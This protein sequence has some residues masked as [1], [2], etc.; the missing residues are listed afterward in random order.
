MAAFQADMQVP[1]GQEWDALATL[2][3]PVEVQNWLETVPFF[4]KD[5]RRFNAETIPTSGPVFLTDRE[6][7][8]QAGFGKILDQLARSNDPVAARI[9]TTSPDVTVSTNLGGWV[10]RKGLF[11]REGR[12]DTF[13]AEKIP[14]TQKWQFSPDGQH[15][16]LGIAEMNLPDEQP[17]LATIL[18]AG[19]PLHQGLLNYFDRADNA[20]VSA[21]RKYNKK[22]SF[23]IMLDYISSPSIDNRILI[24]SDPMLATGGSLLSALDGLLAKGKPKHIHIVC[25][26]ASE[27]GIKA[28]KKRYSLRKLS[29]WIGAID[30]ELTAKAFIVP[31]LGDAGDLA[32][33][34]KED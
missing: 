9:V 25:V 33:G 8:T 7:S 19:L 30:D 18:R 20:F 3:N 1:E 15:I 12:A 21:Y 4:A 5:T 6:E 27:E 29:L 10:N 28:L 23:R 26:L 32:F 34:K 16:E 31:G 13:R 14:S 24:L 17:V 22:G 11:A 2:E